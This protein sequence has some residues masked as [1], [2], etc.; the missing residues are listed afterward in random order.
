MVG[1]AQAHVQGESL[2]VC[3]AFRLR[4]LN[5]PAARTGSDAVDAEVEQVPRPIVRVGF[6]LNVSWAIICAAVIVG[7]SIIGAVV[8][9][10]L[11]EGRYDLF[12]ADNNG[13][14]IGWRLNKRTGAI[15]VCGLAP[16]PNPF[17]LI[18]PNESTPIRPVD[19]IV[20]ECG[21]E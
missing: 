3:A 1:E 12:V 21:A 16:Q 19:R 4:L 20:V 17:V 8:E 7:L 11:L 18:Q 9:S 14:P 10:R 13:S 2:K 6:R 5:S 15:A